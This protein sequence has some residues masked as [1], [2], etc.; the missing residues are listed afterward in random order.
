[1]A[2]NR[3]YLGLALAA[4]L[5]VAACTSAVT[6]TPEESKANATATSV[7]APIDTPAPT[8]PASETS[9]AA[10]IPAAPELPDDPTQLMRATIGGSLAAIARKMVAS[11]NLSYIPVLLEFMRFQVGE[12]ARFSIASLMNNLLEGPGATIIPPERTT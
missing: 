2:A 12:E 3:G 11:E 5:L 10:P 1:M 6:G 9:T 8:G 7:P 4:L